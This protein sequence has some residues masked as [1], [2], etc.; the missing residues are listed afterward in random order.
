MNFE[1][2]NHKGR[3]IDNLDVKKEDRYLYFIYNVK[4]GKEGKYKFCINSVN[5][6]TKIVEMYFYKEDKENTFDEKDINN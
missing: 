4:K 6:R 1:F 5:F 2:I 3:V